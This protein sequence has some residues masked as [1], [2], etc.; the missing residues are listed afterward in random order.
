MMCPHTNQGPL[1]H[2]NVV[3]H[4]KACIWSEECTCTSLGTEIRDD[5]ST[6]FADDQIFATEVTEARHLAMTCALFKM[7]TYS[8]HPERVNNTK[9]ENMK[10]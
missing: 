3:W 9:N 5:I 1:E 10:C 6:R 2:H 8:S 7:Y 4:S